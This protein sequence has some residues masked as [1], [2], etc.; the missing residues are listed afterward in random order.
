MDVGDD[1]DAHGR[2]TVPKLLAAVALAAAWIAAAV[3]LWQT[4]VPDLELPPARPGSATSR[5][6]SSS[7]SRTSAGSRGRSAS[8][9]LA[10]ELVV[11]AAFVVF[12]RRLA[13]ASGAVARGRVRTG[14]SLALLAVLALWLAQ[15]PLGAA[16]TGGAAATTCREQGYAGWFLDSV[17]GLAIQA[18]LV[19]VAVAGA[20]LLWRAA[21]A[22]LV[23][24]RRAGARRARGRVRPRRSR[25]S[26]SRSSTDFRP[27]AD[28]ALARRDPA[29]RGRGR[30]S[31]STGRGRGRE[32]PDDDA[33]TPTSPGSARRGASSS[34]TRS[35]TG[36]SRDGEIARGR[37]ARARA[38][39]AAAP[40]EGP[41]AG[42]R[43]SPC[44]GWLLV[45][46]A[47]EPARRARATPAVVPL[48][49]LVA[50]LL[51]LATLPLQNAI[52]RRYEAEA[53]WIALRATGDPDAATA[54]ER[55]FVATSLADPDPPA[56]RGR[57]GSGR[58]RRR[59]TGS[60]WRGRTRREAASARSPAGS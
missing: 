1:G 27:L 30:A 37:R 11:L 53:D 48:G 39:R 54:L 2:V 52:S 44:P 36:A 26:S 49:L 20:M 10:V 32:P 23:A 59:S 35:W 33:R 9:S 12:A 45:A 24:R 8:A 43:S 47:T 18:V 17:V 29:A 28:R 34:R 55:R 46:W 42:S 41:R 4:E 51:Y 5:P 60:R 13:G 14:V 56:L 40:L 31:T 15:L 50:L 57:S 21:R 22:A 16:A 25:S 3:L 7:E 38:R 58:T 19:A 6:A